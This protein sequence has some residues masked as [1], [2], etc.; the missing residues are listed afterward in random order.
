[1][2]LLTQFTIPKKSM[3]ALDYVKKMQ[4]LEKKLNQSCIDYLL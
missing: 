3:R 1:M 2:K 4:I